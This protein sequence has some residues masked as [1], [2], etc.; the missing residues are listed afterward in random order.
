MKFEN[1]KG[2]NPE[3]ITIQNFSFKNG[4]ESVDD[5]YKSIE[6]TL[7]TIENSDNNDIEIHTPVIQGL[8][9]YEILVLTLLVRNLAKSKRILVVSPNMMIGNILK[10]LGMDVRKE[11]NNLDNK[12]ISVISYPFFVKEKKR[13]FKEEEFDFVLFYENN[14]TFL[15]KTL[16][17]INSFR[18]NK[19]DVKKVTMTATYVIQKRLEDIDRLNKFR[20]LHI[21]KKLR[22]RQR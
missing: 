19:T 18:K 11:K 10:D 13:I 16:K 20:D 8:K 22:P 17:T 9:F 4:K 5:Y 3:I 14:Y 7:D 15:S 2:L 12:K 1:F 21:R 6:N